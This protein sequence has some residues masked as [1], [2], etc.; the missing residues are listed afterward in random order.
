MMTTT[1]DGCR[2]ATAVDG[3]ARAPSIVLSNSLGTDMRLW[4]GQVGRLSQTLRVWR[5]DMRGHGGSEAPAADYTIARLGRD[6]LSIMDANAIA[7]AHLCGISIGGAVSLWVAAHAPE[8]VDRLVL[9]NTGARI[10]HDALW[11]ERI[12]IARTAGLSTLADAAMGRW[13]TEPF[14]RC[15]P[16]IVERFHGTICR[17]SVDGY[18]G[19]CAALRDADLRPDAKRI[20]AK[21]LVI[22]GTHDVA[23]TTADGRWLVEA[24]AGATLVELDSAHLSN[25]ERA[26]AFNDTVLAFLQ[27]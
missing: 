18:V 15:E 5:Y 21:T 19:C 9:A 17:T 10:G 13:F 24:I 27:S 6:L 16:A 12:Q 23:T 22:T 1:D 25:V 3:P 8:R 2:L 7:T 11:N 14:R 20:T 4:D 26:E